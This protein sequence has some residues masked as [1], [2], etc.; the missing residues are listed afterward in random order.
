MAQLSFPWPGDSGAGGTG[1]CGPYT[2]DAFSNWYEKMFC[3]DSTNE[4]VISNIGNELAVT[5]AATPLSINTG[6][7]LVNGKFYNNSAST[8]LA[9]ATPAGATRI[10]RVILRA[11]YAAQTVRL[12]LLAGAEG[13]AAPA[14][15]QVDGTTWEVSL[16]QASITTGGVVTVTDER[17]F[18]HFNTDVETAMIEDSAVTAAK[19]A[20]R[21][22]TIFI[23]AVHAQ[24][25]TDAAAI[26]M[27]TSGLGWIMPDNKACAAFGFF[28]VPSDFVS[29]ATLKPVMIAQSAGNAY[30][31]TVVQYS[32]IDETFPT[33]TDTCNGVG[34]STVACGNDTLEY[35]A[36]VTLSTPAAGDFFKVST[37][38]DG[39]DGTDTL[40]DSLT[41]HGWL[42]SYTADS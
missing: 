7:A 3:S 12:V 41:L 10:D 33:H 31:R 35:G 23:P 32:A 25:Q 11:D 19:I 6:S 36:T 16:A 1:D 24:N 14:L 39:T 21:T 15:T 20:N 2:A 40:T 28:S 17:G 8:T 27:T 18:L 4:S 26:M 42:L 9:I 30:I 29:T 13:G 38:R 34:Y 37:T 5:G 22:R